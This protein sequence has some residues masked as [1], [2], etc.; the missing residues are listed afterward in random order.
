MI[1]VTAPTSKIGRQLLDALVAETEP[2]RAIARDPCKLSPYERERVDIVEGS[3][4]DREVVERAFAGA[5]A[6]LWLVPAATLEANA[7]DAYVGFSKAACGAF[8]TAGVQ[9]VVGISSVGRGW[10]KDAGNIS[11]TLEL[12]DMIAETGVSYRALTCATFMDNVLRQLAAIKTTGVLSGTAAGA[13]PL[14]MC[15]T[16]D[17][18]SAATSLLLDETW[19]GRGACSILGPEDLSFNDVAAIMADVLGRPVRYEQTPLAAARTGLMSRGLSAGMTDSVINMMIA[20]NE[21]IDRTERRSALSTT[22]TTFRQFCEEVLRP[23]LLA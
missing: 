1:V 16:R 7:H 12:D 5:R 9:Q 11:A 14:A 20:Q 2:V 21:G 3:H 19:T 18:A 4:R 6:V 10:P 13:L 15:A 17:I 22:P 8:R 23:A